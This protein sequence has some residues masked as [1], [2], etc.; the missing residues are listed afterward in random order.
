MA[1]FCDAR[2]ATSLARLN[3]N[4]NW[5]IRPKEYLKIDKT[6]FDLVKDFRIMLDQL[7]HNECVQF[8]LDTTFAYDKIRDPDDEIMT[9]YGITRKEN[10]LILQSLDALL[11]LSTNK[12]ICNEV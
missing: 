3:C 1:Q 11:H 12:K 4:R 10:D 7:S 5:F 9:S 2:T 8:V 6:K